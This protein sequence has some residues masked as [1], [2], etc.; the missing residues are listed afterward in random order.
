[1]ANTILFNS[2]PR[3]IAT[4]Y[5]K[6]KSITNKLQRT[7]SGMAFIKK[8]LHHDLVP[9]F[10]KV[11]G[12]FVNNKDKTRVDRILKRRRVDIKEQFRRT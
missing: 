4:D 3:H 12:Q 8:S 11:Q 2:L 7:P 6:L 1:M 9:T 5:L 10:A